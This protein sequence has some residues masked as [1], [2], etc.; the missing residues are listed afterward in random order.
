MSLH[1]TLHGGNDQRTGGASSTS[2]AQG[3]AFRLNGD[4]SLIVPSA[5]NTYAGSGIFDGQVEITEATTLTQV[6]MWQRLDGD[7]GSTTVEVYYWDGAAWAEIALAAALTIASGG[8]NNAEVT[9]AFSA[10][11]AVVAGD[12]IGVQFTAVQLAGAGG[13]PTDVYVA[14]KP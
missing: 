11:L 7:S 10:P 14:V 4:V 12:R 5:A 9:I 3:V 8:G 6:T 1:G 13:T 2:V